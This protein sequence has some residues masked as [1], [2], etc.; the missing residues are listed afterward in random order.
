MTNWYKFI[1]SIPQGK[2]QTPT[3]QTNKENGLAAMNNK[4]KQQKC[5]IVK[6]ITTSAQTIPKSRKRPA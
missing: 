6:L 1:E 4:S 3:R 5:S 2:I